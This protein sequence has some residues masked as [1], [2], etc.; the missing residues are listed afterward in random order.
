MI[1]NRVR[2]LRKYQNDFTIKFAEMMSKQLP[3]WKVVQ[4]GKRW[5]LCS[6]QSI[7]TYFG[8]SLLAYIPGKRE[9]N[10][11]LKLHFYMSI[12]F[13]I[14][15]VIQN[16]Y[17]TNK[18][19]QNAIKSMLFP[20]L[21]KVFGDDI[22][23]ICQDMSAVSESLAGGFI[24]S[25]D[26]IGILSELSGSD[27]SGQTLGYC[28][29]NHVFEVSQLYPREIT[30]R[31]DD[32]RFY[33]KYNNVEFIINE[34]DFGW[35]ERDKHRTYHSM[36]KGVAMRFKLNKEIKS[37]VLIVSKGLFNKIPKGFEKVEVEYNKFARKYNVYVFD[38]G[39]QAGTG[40]IEARYLLNTAFLDR[41]MQLH[42]SFAIPKLQCSVYGSD[43]LI[44]LN[45]RKDLFELNHLFG[46]I[47]DITQ[48]KHLFDEFASVLSFIDV[49]NLSSKTKL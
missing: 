22:H 36:F 45:T 10:Y 23:Y 21:V 14:G 40:Q 19:Y 18:E 5:S 27:G 29:P 24:S 1:D 44:M 39:S 46:R 2:Q 28:I 17:S 11:N 42:T 33:G 26:T 48:Y 37:R 41:F 8:I 35:N 47:D 43:M 38:N 31:D 32:D 7:L 6:W 25:K 9:Y 3:I 12:V 4:N 15:A 20:S 30:Q 13:F 34:T 16:I 49:L